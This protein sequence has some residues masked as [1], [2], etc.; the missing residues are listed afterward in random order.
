MTRRPI[1]SNKL[2]RRSE[3]HS[4]PKLPSTLVLSHISSA[5]RRLATA[6]SGN[7][8][9]DCY[10]HSALAQNLLT[11]LGF[12]ST[13]VVGY[14]A[15]RVGAG[16]SDVIM[17]APLPHM[18]PQ[19]GVAF[20]V[21]LELDSR[22]LDFTT[23]QLPQKAAQLDALDGGTTKVQWKPLY[24]SAPKSSVSLLRNVVQLR[25]GLYYYAREAE[26]E[27]RVI[28]AAEA[29]DEDDAAT[30]WLLYQNQGL[31]VFGPC[32]MPRD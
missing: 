20:H 10:M 16:D 17:H 18:P 26:L 25:A 12:D 4:A 13:L 7:F 32:N 30:A 15:W 22:L 11:R 9:S 21:W 19:P 24:L 28:S 31:Q 3:I 14:A 5:I 8:G 1:V 2:K 29:I 6:A 23:Y 27:A